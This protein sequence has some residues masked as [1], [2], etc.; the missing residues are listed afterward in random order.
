[1][2]MGLLFVLLVLLAPTAR[3]QSTPTVLADQVLEYAVHPAYTLHQYTVR[4]GLPSNTINIFAQTSD[5]YL[6]MGTNEGLVR[7][8]GY[9]FTLFNATNTPALASN[10]IARVQEAPEGLLWIATDKGDLALYREGHFTRLEAQTTG[11]ATWDPWV[12]AEADT[13]WVETQR[14][15]GRYVDGHLERYR[16]DVIEGHVHDILRDRAGRLWVALLQEEG[17]YRLDPTGAVKHFDLDGSGVRNLLLDR[18]N[19][20]WIETWQHI[21]RMEDDRVETLHGA[22]D[23]YLNYED[24]EGNVWITS[25]NEGWWRHAPSGERTLAPMSPTQTGVGHQL[26]GPEGRPWRLGATEERGF[27]EHVLFQDEAPIFRIRD[28]ISNYYFDRRGSLWI[29]TQR[30]GLFRLQR[31]FLRVLSEAEGLPF[32][33]VYPVLEDETGHIWV[34]TFGEGVARFDGVGRATVFSPGASGMTAHVVSLYEDRAG[35]VW[36]GSLGPTCY[37]QGNRCRSDALPALVHVGARAMVEDRQGRFWIGGEA[38]LVVGEGEGVNRTWARVTSPEGMPRTWV[39]AITETRDGALLF[40]TNGDGILRYLEEGTDT[41]EVL[42]TDEGLPSGLVRDLYEDREGYLWIALEDQGL[43]RLDRQ[44]YTALADGELRCLDSRQ[45]L[46]QSGLHR[47]LEDDHGRFW[48]N[49]NNG[50][51][52]VEYE[53]LQ[54]FFAGATPSVTSVSYTEAEGMRNREGNGGMQPAGIKVQDG[55]LWFPTQDGVVVVDPREVPLPEAPPVL[56]EAVQV[57]EEMR[58]AD[59]MVTLLAGEQDVTIH[60]AALEFARAVDVRFQYRLEGYDEGWR[61]GGGQRQ[62]TYTNLSPGMYTF[63]VRA[64]IGG[65]WGEAVPLEIKR[66]PYLWERGWFYALVAAF[67][68]V[69]GSMVY[70]LRVRRLKAREAELEQIVEER[71]VELRRANELKSR[72]LANISH[73]FRTPLTL[74]FGPIDDLLQGRFGPMEPARPHFERARRNGNRLLRLINQL[75]DLSRLD[76]GALL[77]HARRLDLAQF[78]R[79]IIAMFESLA[80]AQGVHFV[81]KVPDESFPYVFDPDK[82]EKVVIN[83]VSNAFKF[84]PRGG[85]ISLVLSREEDGA[86][87][88]EVADTG[89]GIAAE[90]LPRLFDRFYQVEGSSTRKHEGSGIGLALVKELIELHEGTITVESTVGFGTSFTVMLPVLASGKVAPHKEAAAPP[91]APTE[92]LAE[93]PLEVA[94]LETAP[95]PAITDL[96]DASDEATIVLLVEDNADMRAYIRAHLEG[97]FTL[98]E[99]ENGRVGVDRAQELVP[100]LVLSDVMMPEMDGLELCQAL[101]TDTRTSHIPVVLLTAKAQ[102]EH[103]IAGFE[104]GADAYLPK[105][106]NAE[107]LQVRVRTLIEERKRLRARFAGLPTQEPLP[108]DGDALPPHEVAFLEQAREAVAA[109]MKDP[110]FDVEALAEALHLSRRQLHRKLQ[111]LQAET[112]SDLI[113]RTRLERAVVLLGERDLLIK[114]IGYRVGFRSDSAFTRAFRQVYGMPPSEYARQ[115]QG[116]S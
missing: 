69:I 92:P 14:G 95:A 102:V 9:T 97:R 111:A 87:R 71:T 45:G 4:D 26:E 59:S 46:Y 94:P 58:H 36:V 74:T 84:T 105:P 33:A 24:A 76:A 70:G 54:A 66:L 53:Q 79:Q 29:G 109:G 52:W 57:G 47:I 51:F 7:F 56:L 41:F 1:M 115:L 19:R 15:L 80:H 114:E 93:A 75:L 10:R 39:R 62:A 40:G 96:E 21:F 61:D 49:T 90:H 44:G 101:K 83:L 78:L 77:L 25:S 107:E 85:K 50:L 91:S 55:R 34:G 68:L 104:S 37:I 27:V 5:G 63:L 32:R 100:D 38:G 108:V 16:P 103:R 43:C 17:L 31:A 73:E 67:V 2:R 28:E 3:A 86:A 60:F 13:V 82:L 99:A 22:G 64:G 8:D 42:S 30:H 35:T 113:R 98:V 23:L 110:S 106:F 12:Y 65:V 20:L 48:F 112:P 18:H 11:V 88:I 6:W 72:F 116:S 81:A 89:P